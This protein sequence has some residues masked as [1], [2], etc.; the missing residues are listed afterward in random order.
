M[1]V[2]VHIRIY[3]GLCASLVCTVSCR[4]ACEHFPQALLSQEGF[5]KGQYAA[6]LRGAYLQVDEALR[7]EASQEELNHL[8]HHY[9]PHRQR[10]EDH[11]I[12]LGSHHPPPPL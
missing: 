6:A 1:S 3:V 2:D 12:V 5:R 8:I 10:L 11:A 4:F 9:T 7:Q